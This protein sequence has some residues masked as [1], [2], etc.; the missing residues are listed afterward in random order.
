VSENKRI[1]FHLPDYIDFDNPKSGSH[2]RPQKIVSAFKELGFVVDV[3][4]G[5]GKQRKISITKI[6]QNVKNG[7]NYLFLYSESSTSPTLLTERNHIPLYPF[8]DF[9]FFNYCKKNNIPVGLFYR[10]IQW[11]F[12]FYDINYFKR[13]VAKIF[14]FYDLY[15]YNRHVDVIYL[16]SKK[17]I[18][19]IPLRL[20]NKL[21]ELPPGSEL[22]NFELKETLSDNKLTILYVGGLGK[23]YDI[24]LLFKVV[25]KNSLFRLIVCTRENEWVENKYKYENYLSGNVFVVHKSNEELIDLYK[26]AD[27]VSLFVN[28]IEYWQFVMPIKMFEYLSFKK[29]IICSNNILPSEFILN[30]NIGWSVEYSSEKLEELLLRIL[31]DKNEICNK[32]KS[33]D[34]VLLQNTWLSRCNFIVETLSNK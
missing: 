13:I 25:S 20:M 21:H 23:L 12:E 14:Y 4:T 5:Y 26:E 34:K 27:L 18:D 33:I 11:C 2:K 16:P 10:D 32:V 29:P 24:E 7:C 6:K 17:M 3:V 30:N 28:P 19:Y 31:N 9:N 8:L 15:Q 1:I 22:F